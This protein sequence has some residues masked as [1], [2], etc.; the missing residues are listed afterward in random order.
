M[1]HPPGGSAAREC[2]V[3]KWGMKWAW[4]LGA[5]RDVQAP[6]RKGPAKFHLRQREGTLAAQNRAFPTGEGTQ[7]ALTRICLRVDL[8]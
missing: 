1:L 6:L 8:T 2:R 5:G 7:F 4:G 3:G